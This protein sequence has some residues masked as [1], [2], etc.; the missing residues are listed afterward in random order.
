[1]SRDP[2]GWVDLHCHFLPGLDDGPADLQATVEMLRVAYRDGTRTL[3]ATPHLFHPG[4]DLERGKIEDCYQRTVEALG[5]WARERADARFL[6]DLTFVLGA[7]NH[8]G[9]ELLVDVHQGRAM[10][11]G[12]SPWLLVE[13]SVFLP[14]AGIEEA[15]RRI[16]AAGYRP[17]LAHIERYPA[18]A[19]QPRRLEAL[20]ASGC[21]LQVNAGGVVRMKSWRQGRALRRLFR[22]GLVLC[23]ASDGHDTERRPL[24]LTSARAELE[25]RYGWAKTCQWLAEGP[26]QV[27]AESAG[28]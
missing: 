25:R 5:S 27:L 15:A 2:A 24:S 10:T 21:A 8:L 16:L 14:P 4:F 11:L 12:E 20:V 22:R 23:V 3:V 13:P 28:R 26:R 9:P 7:E 17:L 6:R 1:M 18:L 19:E